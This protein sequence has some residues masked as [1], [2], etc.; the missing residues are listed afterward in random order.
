MA[1]DDATDIVPADQAE[2]SNGANSGKNPFVSI[3]LLLNIIGLIG[4]GYMQ[5]LSFYKAKNEPSIKDVV[6]AQLQQRDSLLD[7][8][9]ESEESRREEEQGKLLP[10]EGFTANLAQ[11]DGPRRYLRLK[12]VLKFNNDSKPEEFKSRRPQI[13]DTVISLLNSKRPEDLLKIE[14]KSYLKEEIKTSIN[15]F[16][17]DGRIIDIYYVG[18]QIN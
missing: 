14:G 4:V 5:Y 12:I 13:R 18:F 1:N 6:A 2:K 9:N 11:T 8:E 3:L 16:L 17:T 10:L 7:S 15:S